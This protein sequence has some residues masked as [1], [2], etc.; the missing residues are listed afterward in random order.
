MTRHLLFTTA[1]KITD[2]HR[3][4]LLRLEETEDGALAQ[5]SIPAASNANR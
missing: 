1:R 3:G 2:S 5:F 4:T